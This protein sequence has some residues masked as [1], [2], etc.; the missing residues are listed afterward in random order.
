[1]KRHRRPGKPS[2][3][4]REGVIHFLSCLAAHQSVK[5]RKP[6]EARHKPKHPTSIVAI[7]N[8]LPQNRHIPVPKHSCNMTGTPL[9]LCLAAYLLL[10]GGHPCG[11]VVRRERC[12]YKELRSDPRE[13]TVHAR[14][15]KQSSIQG[16][17][18]LH[19]VA[20][21][22]AL[23]EL[24]PEGLGSR[25]QRRR[26]LICRA[27]NVD[28]APLR[29]KET[30][31]CMDSQKPCRVGSYSCRRS[32]TCATMHTATQCQNGPSSFLAEAPA[33]HAKPGRPGHRDWVKDICPCL[34]WKSPSLLADHQHSASRHASARPSS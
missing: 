9:K 2:T 1:M 32:F 8:N 33:S 4:S 14:S 12:T 25:A 20:D 30:S 34:P 23:H 28:T 11:V 13:Q 10:P 19:G 7:V 15:C 29:L 18:N 24:L 17:S 5:D 16:R 31:G 6:D 22:N 3:S 27:S 26:T 21:A